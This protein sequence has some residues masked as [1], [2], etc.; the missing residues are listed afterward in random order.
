MSLHAFMAACRY[1]SRFQSTN[2]LIGQRRR[3]QF[4]LLTAVLVADV[5][6]G[7]TRLLP[8]A[9]SKGLYSIEHTMRMQL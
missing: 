3:R 2:L 1:M 9:P 4:L 5:S 8:H 6:L 7:F